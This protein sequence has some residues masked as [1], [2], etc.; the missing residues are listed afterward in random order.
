MK[1]ICVYVWAVIFLM[2]GGV[3]AEEPEREAENNIHVEEVAG[4]SE[5]GEAQSDA[6]E[7]AREEKAQNAQREEVQPRQQRKG[8]G[9]LVVPLQGVVNKAQL[10]FLRRAVKTAEGSQMEAILLDMDTPGGELQVAVEMVDILRSTPLETA[11]YVNP[12]AASAG[13]LIALATDRIY[14]SPV[15]AIGAAAPVTGGGED[16][17]ESM[18]S[19][20]VS[21]YSK[22]FRSAAEEE[23]HNPDIAEAFIN[24]DKEVK[25]GDRVIS[26]K[27]ELLSLSPKEAAEMI[28]G[29]PV[30]SSGNAENLSDLVKL[31]GWEGKIVQHEPS[32]FESLAMLIA[33]WAPILLMIGIAAVYLEFQSPGIGLP[34][35]VAGICFLLFF[36]GHYFAGL[37]GMEVVAIFILGAMLLVAEFIFFPGIFILAAMGTLMMLGALFVTMVDYY[38]AQ[39]WSFDWQVLLWPFVN[40]VFGVVGA[41]VLSMVLVRYLPRT[42]LFSP[43]VLTATSAGEQVA[44][45]SPENLVGE[46]GQTISLLRP[47]GRVEVEGTV[48]DAMSMGEYLEPGV[49]VKLTDFRNGQYIVRKVENA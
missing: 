7:V 14:M 44:F 10:A 23:G 5:E 8:N 3:F 35:I 27:G 9:V 13:A 12:N 18:N 30:L 33:T 32:G 29:K 43:L 25:I 34:A 22:Y 39:E 41:G 4:V 1:S 38:P 2:G 11:T 28:D 26:P 16:L 37:S 19:K 20:V 45:D 40:M 46:T 6:E 42:S 31:A 47:S 24:K 17:N 15:A 48:V 21:Y 36:G 49:Q